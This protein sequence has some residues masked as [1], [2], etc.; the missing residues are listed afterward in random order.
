M[1]IGRPPGRGG[2]GGAEPDPLK[3]LADSYERA[4]GAPPDSNF[5]VLANQEVYGSP[6][7]GHTDLLFSHPVYWSEKKPGQPFV[8]K[9][10]VRG[11]VY[12][13]DGADEFIEMARRENV[14]ISMPHPRT[15]KGSTGYTGRG[16]GQGLL[17]GPPLSRRRLPLGHGRRSF[18]ATLVREALPRAAGRHE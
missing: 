5:M 14:L 4:P 16:K 8:E 3:L 9:D 1:F 18:R 12:H 13:I 2:R 10:P 7:G 6:L 11:N 15:R 17:S